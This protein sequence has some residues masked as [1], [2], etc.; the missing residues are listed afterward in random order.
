MI[1]VMAFG[2]DVITLLVETD[3]TLSLLVLKDATYN[4]VVEESLHLWDLCF[5]DD[6]CPK[7]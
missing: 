6:D 5:Y 3:G 1:L 7:Q 4:C 2:H